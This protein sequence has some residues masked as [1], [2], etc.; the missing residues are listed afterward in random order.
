MKRVA[1]LLL[2]AVVLSGCGG[3]GFFRPGGEAA[4]ST[5]VCGVYLDGK[6][7]MAHLR[8]EL[9]VTGHVPPGA[10]VEVEFENPAEGKAP[11]VTGRAIKGS[12]ERL[13]IFSPPLKGVRP[14]GYQVVVRIHESPEKKKVLAMHTQLCESLIDQR[15]L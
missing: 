1:P 6:T 5:R 4:V 15:E 9:S 14:R 13:V 2:A 3:A 7:R 11:L 12:S 8:I 10:F